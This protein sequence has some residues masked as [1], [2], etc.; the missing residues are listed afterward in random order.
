M[1]RYSSMA[2]DSSARACSRSA[3]LGIQGAEAEV[4]V[5]HERAHAEFLGQGQGLL[6]VHFGLLDHPG[7]GDGHGRRQAERSAQR[8]V[9]RSLCCRARSSAW[10]ACC[11]ASSSRPV[12]TTDLAEPCDPIGKTSQPARADTF[13]D[14]LL[15]QRA[16]PPRDAPR[17]HRQSPGLLRS[18]ATLVPDCQRHD[19]G[20]GPARTPGWPAPGPL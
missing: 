20:P 11:R 13:A 8:L 4:A 17:A 18:I 5:G 12:S 9:P 15:Q 19:R 6:V 14:R 1:A 3:H 7:V 2:V 10:R 16:T